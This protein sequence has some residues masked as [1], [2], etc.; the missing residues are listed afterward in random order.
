MTRSVY[1]GMSWTGPRLAL[2]RLLHAPLFT[3][4][5]LLTLAIGIGANTA[6]FSVVYGVLLKPLPFAEPERLVAVWHRAPG[7]GIEKLNQ[8]PSTY[9]T[10]RDSGR[11]FQDI[12]IW[13]T[14][15]VSITGRGEPERVGALLV[16]DGTLPLLGVV[17]AKGRLFTRADDS[18]G[19][20]RRVIL[21]HGYWQRRFG[22]SDIVG[23]SM[24]VDGEPLEIIGVLPATFRFLN[25]NPSIVLPLQ[26]DRTK[27]FVGNFSYQGDGT[28]QARR[29]AGAGQRR[30]WPPAAE[31]FPT[32]TRCRR[33]SRGRCM[34]T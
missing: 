14:N 23:Q 5:T 1:P 27:I 24:T 3:A 17:P 29:D 7:L 25:E 12:G 10:V 2:R 22:G 21:T 6:I 28:P 9:L 4:V 34:T 8:S 16:T 11:V 13:T 33:V 26:F 15:A 19:T 31:A 20:P 32:T 30:R 18:P